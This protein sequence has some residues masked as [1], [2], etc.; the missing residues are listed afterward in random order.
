MKQSKFTI[1]NA[2]G[3]HSRPASDFCTEAT[4]YGCKVTLTKEGDD[5]EY[6]GKSILMVMCLG[7]CKGDEITIQTEGPDE[8]KALES[9]LNI[10]K[11]V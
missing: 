3:L 8:E 9:L 2:E 7:A 4:K 10:L 1:Q 6:D 11:N 5:N